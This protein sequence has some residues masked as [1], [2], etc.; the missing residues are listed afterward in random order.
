MGI[1]ICFR[2]SLTRKLKTANIKGNSKSYMRGKCNRKFGN[3][4][5]RYIR[6]VKWELIEL[7]VAYMF[8]SDNEYNVGILICSTYEVCF[9]FGTYT[10][11]E[12]IKC[13]YAY[14]VS[15]VDCVML[16]SLD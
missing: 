9:L 4:A 13:Q 16:L 2:F 5:N 3:T 10:F 14:V 8:C 6:T 7:K 1:I 15:F 12:T 11:A